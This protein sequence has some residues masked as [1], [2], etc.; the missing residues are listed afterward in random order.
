[1]MGASVNLLSPDAIEDIHM[2]SLEVLERTGVWVED[3][4]ALDLYSDARC[5]VDRETHIVRIPPNL[6]EDAIRSAP[7]Y[8]RTGARDP[9]KDVVWGGNRTTFSNFLV[10]LTVN[11]LETGQRRDSVLQDVADVATIF[12]TLDNIDIYSVPVVAA[13]SPQADT[14]CLH[15]YAA[16]L[17]HT[18]KAI[19]PAIDTVLGAQGC[20]EIAATVCG[21]MDELRQRQF[22][23]LGACTVSPLKLPADA[24]AYILLAARN[25]LVSGALSM[26][27]SGA[28]SPASMA[29]VLAI[30]NAELLAALVLAQHVEPGLPFGYC[31]SGTSM[32][33]RYATCPVGSP[34]A[35]FCT[36][37]T[38]QLAQRHG[39]PTTTGGL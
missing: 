2:A 14:Q 5:Y 4:E 18:S 25:G 21:G 39:L 28:T 16:A 27:M 23:L 22:A 35:A 9:D 37:G 3:D 36:V 33:M 17:N 38:A 11:D 12:D 8:F 26:P 30:Q 19:M 20:I 1:M 10:G 31:T 24:T 13:D 29:S 15:T 7:P 34:E 32:D 6:V